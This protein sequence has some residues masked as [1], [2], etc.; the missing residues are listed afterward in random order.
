MRK[1]N[2]NKIYLNQWIAFGLVALQ[3]FLFTATQPFAFRGL[4]WYHTLAIS[5]S[6]FLL[7]K[8]MFVW[9]ALGRYKWI[10]I[11]M[12]L[13]WLLLLLFTKNELGSMVED[14]F[15]LFISVA[16]II[17]M[18][19]TLAHPMGRKVFFLSILF[20]A[21][22]RC[23]V[24]IDYTQYDLSHNVGLSGFGKDKNFTGMLLAMGSMIL[25]PF[26][27]SS[28]VKIRNRIGGS[29]LFFYFL[30]WTFITG[31]RSASISIFLSISILAFMYY[32]RIRGS[33]KNINMMVFI[34]L[35]AIIS[36]GTISAVTSKYGVLKENYL[37]LG[38]FAKG[39]RRDI[40]SR[41]FLVDLSIEKIKKQPFIGSGVGSSAYLLDR[42]FLT[43]NSYLSQWIEMGL[44]GIVSFLLFAIFISKE[45]KL[46]LEKYLNGKQHFDLGL[47]LIGLP[48]IFML[49]A[50][51]M[52]LGLFLGLFAA[53]EY[54]RNQNWDF[55]RKTS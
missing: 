17:L 26:V 16:T 30:Y 54:E 19:T 48:L 23:F 46:Q 20:T 5:L 35:F 55:K 38:E 31:S 47:S 10:Y 34:I 43:H 24:V 2:S 52:N 13:G 36:I 4:R 21:L 51:N 40:N 32:F 12:G 15:K 8:K 25:V 3:W 6:A 50:L 14:V 7:T 45:I 11:F 39:E 1:R 27:L 29:I 28:K 37:Q 42:Y 44:P 53:F 49:A 18:I 22:L 9:K 41:R 33:G